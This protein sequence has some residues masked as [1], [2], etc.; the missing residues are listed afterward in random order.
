MKVGV[1]GS[2]GYA[3]QQLVGLLQKHPHVDIEFLSS[4]S[5]EDKNYSD[6]YKVYK[7]TINH[8]CIGLDQALEVSGTIDVLFIALP[9]GKSLEI[10][11]KI[12]HKGVKIIDFGADFRLNDV[13]TIKK[14]YDLEHKDEV[15][16]HSAVYGLP[17]LNR[18]TIKQAT[19]V[20]NPG[21]Y[22]TASILGLLPIV[23]EPF[24]DLS[25]IIIDAKSGVTGAGRKETLALS[26]C[27]TN[28]NFKAYSVA[29]HR[30]TPEIEAILSEVTKTRIT[31]SFT[32]HLVPMQRGILATIYLNL[33]EAVDINHVKRLY[34]S[35]YE[36]DYFVRVVDVLPETKHVS[37]TNFCDICIKHDPRTNRLIIVSALD[38]LV[39]G[40]AGEAVQN[41]N[42]MMGYPETTGLESGS[43][44]L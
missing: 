38:N 19:F 14:W 39:K 22:P 1:I 34:E 32:P 5:Y 13:D 27:E 35:Y 15:L 17:E 44:Y 2:T 3:G 10:V 20:A 21:C 25:S 26:Y 16:L 24:V 7:N 37:R 31:L 28:E 4:Y 8:Q 40:S 6:V 36:H 42:L 12:K 41:M 11:E 29:S 18:E 43:Y 33:T 9:H 23:K 30:H